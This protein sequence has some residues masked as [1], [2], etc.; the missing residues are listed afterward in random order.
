MKPKLL[1]DGVLTANSAD[2]GTVTRQMVRE[3]TVEQ[4]IVEEGVAEAKHDHMV[5]AARVAASPDSRLV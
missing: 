3:R 5:Q 1:K 4:A 2:S